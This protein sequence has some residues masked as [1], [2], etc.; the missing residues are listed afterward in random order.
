MTSAGP[1]VILPGNCGV[2]SAVEHLPYKEGVTGSN[3]VPRTIRWHAFLFSMWPFRKKRRARVLLL[4]DDAAMQRLVQKLLEREGYRVDVVGNGLDAIEAI[5]RD[6][7]AA[8][9][10]DLMM[11]HEGGMTVIRHLRETTPE[12]LR[13]VI[14]LTATPAA[15]LKS[16]EGEVFAVVHKPFAAS[17]LTA[18][19]KKL[20][21]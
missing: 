11:P 17:D 19:V 20:T 1:V 18:M 21:I 9:L 3:P 12:L 15:V 14:V 4:D 7:Y 6:D 10:L 13:R 5:G 8:M 16:I 2:S